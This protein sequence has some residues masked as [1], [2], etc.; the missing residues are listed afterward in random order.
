MKTIRS[1]LSSL[2]LAATSG[3]AIASALATN[4]RAHGVHEDLVFKEIKTTYHY[5]NGVVAT[6]TV[7]PRAPVA[8]SATSIGRVI[9]RLTLTGLEAG[10]NYSLVNLGLQSHERPVAILAATN[11]NFGSVGDV[12]ENG[13]GPAV[14]V[15]PKI[16]NAVD[17]IADDVN[18]PDEVRLNGDDVVFLSPIKTGEAIE[19]VAVPVGAGEIGETNWVLSD[20]SPLRTGYRG[21]HDTIPARGTPAK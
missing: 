21:S 8:G 12:S 1:V 15:L 14:P 16:V 17:L 2:V 4:L 5:A 11:A 9:Y 13:P 19:I 7:E 3:G 18:K 10:K 6:W 20:G